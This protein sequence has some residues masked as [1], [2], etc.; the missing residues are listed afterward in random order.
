MSLPLPSPPPKWPAQHN[1]SVTS[2]AHSTQPLK[3]IKSISK[4]PE[5]SKGKKLAN[6]TKSDQF[7]E[8]SHSITS[9]SQHLGHEDGHTPFEDMHPE[10]STVKGKM[11]IKANSQMPK[12][13]KSKESGQRQTASHKTCDL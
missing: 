12:M 6:S 9:N 7:E 3:R 11:P 2:H 5:P 13:T 1:E 8:S 4:K 10:A